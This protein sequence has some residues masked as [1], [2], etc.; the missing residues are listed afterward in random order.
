MH[1]IAAAAD[2][3]PPTCEAT[4]GTA[5]F[6]V[7]HRFDGFQRARREFV[8][9]LLIPGGGPGKHDEVSVLS[10]WRALLRIVL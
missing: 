1:N 7:E 9:V 5:S 2:Q 10:A 6:G 4:L 8:I 3:R